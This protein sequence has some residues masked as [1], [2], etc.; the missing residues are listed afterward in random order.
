MSE[1]GKQYILS[2]FLSKFK[3]GVWYSS[4]LLLTPSINLLH[5]ILLVVRPSLRSPKWGLPFSIPSLILLRRH[6]NPQ[7]ESG[8]SRGGKG[9]G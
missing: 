3:M 9:N 6:Q 4:Y 5:P 8:S 2:P 7:P 1:Y